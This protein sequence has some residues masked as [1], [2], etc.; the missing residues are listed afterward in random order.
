MP[1]TINVED[2]CVFKAQ[3][4]KLANGHN[5]KRCPQCQALRRV[6]ILTNNET[7]DMIAGVFKAT[8]PGVQ[9]DPQDVYRQI[10]GLKTVH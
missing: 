6:V 9:L 5:A 1:L 4:E 8:S 7:L 10:Q 3:Q 2:F